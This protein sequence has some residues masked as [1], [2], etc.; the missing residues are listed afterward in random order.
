MLLIEFNVEYL[1]KKTVKGRVVAEFLALNPTS[2][3]QEIELEFPN[4]LVATIKIQGWRMYFNGAVNH[5]IVGIGVILLT[6]K[7]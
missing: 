4:D 7:N 2:Y 3:D 1:T 6:P 5:F